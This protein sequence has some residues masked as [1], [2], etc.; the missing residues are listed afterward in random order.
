MIDYDKNLIE[1]IA[2]EYDF[3]FI[4][5]FGSFAGDIQRK[6]SDIDIAVKS[7][8]KMDIEKYVKVQ[9]AFAEVFAVKG[10][11]IDIVEI[12]HISPILAHQVATRGKLLAGSFVKFEKFRLYALKNY[13]DTKKFRDFTKRYIKQN[14]YA[15]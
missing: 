9:E 12:G 13:F 8:S 14:L 3:D 6:T 7:D 10:E 11:K 5:L 2:Q 1:R 4:A 15:K